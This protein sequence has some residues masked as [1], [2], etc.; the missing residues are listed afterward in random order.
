MMHRW[1]GRLVGAL[2]VLC[3]DASI[4]LYLINGFELENKKNSETNG[5][6][7]VASGFSPLLPDL[8]YLYVILEYVEIE[9]AGHRQ[10]L[11]KKE[12][13]SGS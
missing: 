10:V 4:D 2:P 8:V 3:A 13:R 6:P 5:W 7:H 1:Y 9:L 12:Q 11:E